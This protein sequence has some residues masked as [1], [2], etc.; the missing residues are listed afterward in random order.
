MRKRHRAYWLHFSY[1]FLANLQDLIVPN[2]DLI[3]ESLDQTMLQEIATGIF[4]HLESRSDSEDPESDLDSACEI[5]SG[6]NVL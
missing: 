2:Q 4:S 1:A 5:I 6:W 3:Q